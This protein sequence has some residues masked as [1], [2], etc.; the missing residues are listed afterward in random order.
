MIDTLRP[1]EA[2]H[3]P[4]QLLLNWVE[5]TQ[6]RP[7]RSSCQQLAELPLPE[8]RSRP[9]TR[10][11]RLSVRKW[12][13]RWRALAAAAPLRQTGGSDRAARIAENPSVQGEAGAGFVNSQNAQF[14][15]RIGR[16]SSRRDIAAKTLPCWDGIAVAAGD[17]PRQPGQRRPCVD[18]GASGS[19]A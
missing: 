2:M 11:S 16:G 10:R 14:Q 5:S 8:G 3:S 1:V 6:E 4:V 15:A 17:R 7:I 18:D 9:A 12:P 19:S 13:T